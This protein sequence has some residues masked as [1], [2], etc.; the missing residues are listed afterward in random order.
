MRQR[1]AYTLLEV[2][3]AMAIAVLLLAAV[4]SA[5]GFQVR[6][7]QA[8]RD[9]ID[10][11]TLA[12]SLI[13]R[14]SSDVT[15]AASLCDPARYR[16]QQ[17]KQQSASSSGAG[18]SGAGGSG[19][20]GAGAGAAGGGGAA[21]GAGGP[22]GGAGANSGNTS[23]NSTTT[24]AVILPMGV[25]GD[26]SSLRLFIG[27][28][29]TEVWPA[30]PNDTPPLT[31]DL[32]RISY[33]H[34]GDHGLCRQDIKVVTSADAQNMSIPTDDTGHH[35]L[36]PEVK[37]LEFSYYDGTNWNDTWDSTML[38]PDGVTPVGSPRA[39]SIK[40]GV[41]QPGQ[42]SEK[43]KY[44][45]QVVVI[46][47]ANGPTYLSGGQVNQGGLTTT[48]PS[49]LNSNGPGSSTPGSTTTGK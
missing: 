3:L 36:A 48:G 33:W 47:S 5:I 40:I 38:G 20:G 17:Q 11:A 7:A 30:N 28:Y 49:I 27:R 6:H 13:D 29:P 26:S 46:S 32:H 10:Q 21:G 18:G 41:P 19:A 34:S 43:L 8:G 44:Y 15:A 16:K 2:L 35:V 31:S 37:S 39:V 1:P 23:G 4:Y 9:L 42:K 12:R 22:S 25:M 24:T 14:I 45:R